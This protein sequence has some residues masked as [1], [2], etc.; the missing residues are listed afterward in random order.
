V[1][2]ADKRGDAATG[3]RA[4]AATDV[5]VKAPLA[6]RAQAPLTVAGRAQAPLVAV[7]ALAATI[8]FA[9]MA[10]EA[11]WARM[12]RTWLGGDARAL[13]AALA[14]VL[15]GMAA[16]ALLAG[17]LQRRFGALGALARVELA[18]AVYAALLPWLAPAIEAP[19]G[20]AL[21]ALG[22]GGGFHAVALLV[23]LLALAPAAL[24]LGAGLPLL[25]AA[26][27]DVAH[28]ARD[29]GLLYALHAAGS[30][31][32]GLLAAFVLLPD[33]GIPL[34]AGLIASTQAGAAFV[35]LR[36][37]EPMTRA[38]PAASAAP[39]PSAVPIARDTHG[40][41]HDTLAAALLLTAAALSG[42][43]TLG[44]QS[45]W[46]RLAALAVGPTVQGF[47]LVSAVY[48]LALV[49]GASVGA[50]LIARVRRPALL[51]VVLLALTSAAALAGVTGAGAWPERAVE[52]F[53]DAIGRE[54]A[55]GAPWLLLALMVT[56]VVAGP[57]V[58]ASAAFPALVAARARVS[59]AS[60][61]ADVGALLAA[62]ALGNVL[63]ALLGPLWLV[64]LLGLA[65]ALVV[66]A[67]L[68]AV[69]AL[70]GI[71]A[72]LRERG[73]SKRGESKRGES[74]RGA[75]S[76]AARS[77]SKRGARAVVSPGAPPVRAWPIV[78]VAASLAFGVV[79]LAAR[80][81]PARFDAS[82]LS[83]GPFLYAGPA[84]P[85]LGR[86]VFS[87]DGVDAT[88]TVRETLG[89]RL[90]QID[91]KVDGSSR[92]DLPT[93]TLVGLLPGLLARAPREALVIGLGTGTTVDAVRTLP[94]V[95]RVDVAELVDGV[96]YAAPWFA[97]TTG[98]VLRDPRVHVIAA[99]GALL[100]RHGAR[101][102]DLIV[103]EPSN[104]WVSGMGDLF[105]VETF[106]AARAQLRPGGVFAA[107]FHVYA[108]DLDTVRAIA[109]TFR[110]AFPEAT[111]WELARGEDY[112]LIGRAAATDAGDEAAADAAIDADLL[113]QRLADPET[114]A[115]LRSANIDG[116][117]GLLA[118]FVAGPAG[119]RELAGTAA[120][121]HL[122]DGGLEARA[123]RSM[124]RDA[125][126]DALVAFD[127][128]ARA[129]APL[130]LHASTDAGR[131][132]VEA[133]PASIEA[134]SLARA[135]VLHAAGGDQEGAIAAG[136]R[137]LGLLPD[138]PG[139]RDLVGMLLVARGKAQALDPEGR[140]DARDTMFSVLEVDPPD[141]LLRAD[142]L[143]TLGDLERA[144]DNAARALGY[145]QR[146]RRLVPASVEIAR[147]IA[148]CL[149]ALG[150]HD[151]AER[152]RALIRQLQ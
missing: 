51:V 35:A 15:T 5:R 8:G 143:V 60:A 17:R 10:H 4:Q 96:R 33:L 42:A 39:A 75:V 73:E 29:A 132:L 128:A 95:T 3:A 22:A 74:K 38:A 1:S 82:A 18:A 58:F 146:A 62:G 139:I 84:R 78:L 103:S 102:Y 149:D 71:G 80:R 147:H 140:G 26:R 14:A 19:V 145:Y 127:D 34:A 151:D 152:E 43:G 150:A 81:L 104:P 115:R 12:A 119:V 109:A 89:E 46:T 24:A 65:R 141:P 56:P 66:V 130:S 92:G 117:A 148:E 31:A 40:I 116:G 23:A 86:V 134:G 110:A 136:E 83:S 122:R 114:A 41:A 55:S 36:L 70:V 100:L 111:L 72:A 87:H 44:L 99:D 2:G 68:P 88:V 108:T 98:Q 63:G 69:A 137:A 142:A 129:S 54:D 144:A 7:A 120:V 25:V 48:V 123:A 118:R 16:G 32:G 28:A 91:G 113:A 59:R 79:A 52:V 94:E 131:S 30:A 138:D 27:A 76:S 85:E 107:W 20:M 90:L 61:S 93:Q 57:I 11:L 21:R 67:A 101:R 105:C 9:A 124:Y 126:A 13:A 47:A 37:A 97:R 135:L 53:A 106:R 112:A 121:L 77:E 125:S 49:V 45:L 50:L 133:A 6:G 64:P